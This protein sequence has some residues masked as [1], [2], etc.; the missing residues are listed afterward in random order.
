MEETRGRP[1]K[2]ENEKVQGPRSIRLETDF[3]ELLKLF[4][5]AHKKRPAEFMRDAVQ[6]VLEDMM[7]DESLIKLCKNNNITP[8]VF[9]RSEFCEA[10]TVLSEQN[11]SSTGPLLISSI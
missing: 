10:L 4:C 5:K 6:S 11:N 9:M 2:A 1:P 8:T 7:F 3:D